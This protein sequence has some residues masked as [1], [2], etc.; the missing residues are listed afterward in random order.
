MAEE[1]REPLV[2]ML[3]NGGKGGRVVANGWNEAFATGAGETS[4]G[5]AK[6]W[7]RQKAN[8]A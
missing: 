7:A 8:W 4:S 5:I 3:R 1:R 2:V 6:L